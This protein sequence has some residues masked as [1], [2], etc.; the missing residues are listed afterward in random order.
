[1]LFRVRDESRISRADATLTVSLCSHC[2]LDYRYR[3]YNRRVGI[4]DVAAF[5]RA[6]DYYYGIN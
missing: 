1:M 3:G 5:L 6:K 4:V 2:Y